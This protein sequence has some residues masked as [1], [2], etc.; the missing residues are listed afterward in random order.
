MSC[1]EEQVIRGRAS[2][3]SLW[4][5]ALQSGRGVFP[6]ELERFLE[7]SELF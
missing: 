6:Q 5:A 2:H 3:C 4:A 1:A 7:L